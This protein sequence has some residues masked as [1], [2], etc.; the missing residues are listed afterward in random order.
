MEEGAFVGDDFEILG[1]SRFNSPIMLKFTLPVVIVVPEPFIQR[2]HLSF[3]LLGLRRS[4]LI[5]ATCFHKFPLVRKG[6]HTWLI[7]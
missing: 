5:H 1:S 2:S 3:L 6:V 4:H 7:L